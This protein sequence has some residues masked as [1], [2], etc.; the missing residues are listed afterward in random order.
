M[1]ARRITTILAFLAIAF[2]VTEALQSVA[3]SARSSTLTRTG[4]ALH[5]GTSTTPLPFAVTKVQKDGQD[6]MQDV[7]EM[8]VEVF[9]NEEN[10]S[11]LLKQMQLAYLRNLQY[12]DLRMKFFTSDAQ[13]DL[14]MARQVIPASQAPSNRGAK[15]LDVTKT[16]IYNAKYLDNSKEDD[17]VLGEVLGFVEVTE[18]RFRLGEQYESTGSFSE[19]D[20]QRLR[21]VRPFLS[22]LSVREDA[23]KSGVGSALVDACEDAIQQWPRQYSEIVLQVED[24][25]Q[26]ARKFYEKRGYTAL[27][28]D[29]A[30]RRFDT[31]GLILRRVPTTKVAMRKLLGSRR[32]KQSSSSSNSPFFMDVVDTVRQLVGSK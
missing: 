17:F 16:K 14:F 25:N 30:C 24:Q 19:G 12:G 18:K 8:C 31:N 15:P 1:A 13:S 23:R 7:S 10:S 27:F 20:D 4:T 22:N 21:D 11:N 6:D 9:F 26:L 28:A 29:P 3:S 2:I 5:A 32:R